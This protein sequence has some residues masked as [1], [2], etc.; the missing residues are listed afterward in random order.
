M[1][2]IYARLSIDDRLFVTLCHP[3]RACPAAIRTVRVAHDW[4]DGAR[5]HAFGAV[6]LPKCS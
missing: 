6:Y 3:E 4:I 2:E 1:G 5:G